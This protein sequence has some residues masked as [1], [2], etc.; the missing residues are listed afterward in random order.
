MCSWGCHLG[1][2]QMYTLTA[3]SG[4]DACAVTDVAK[5]SALSARKVL[6]CMSIVFPTLEEKAGLGAEGYKIAFVTAGMKRDKLPR[7]VSHDPM[8]IKTWR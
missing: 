7:H 4:S 8:A 6:D 1:G 3:Q 5:R 2:A